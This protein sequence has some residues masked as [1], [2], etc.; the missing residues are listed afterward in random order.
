MTTF[1]LLGEDHFVLGR[2]VHTL[3]VLMYLA[4]NTVVR[5]AA[6]AGREQETSS[7]R[8][9]RCFLHHHCALG[10]AA[11]RLA[12]SLSHVCYRVVK[13]AEKKWSERRHGIQTPLHNL[14][15]LLAE[16]LLISV[17]GWAHHFA[18]LLKFHHLQNKVNCNLDVHNSV[19]QGPVL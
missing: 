3:A 19:S 1:D 16:E 18:L 17:E 6:G 11:L 7:L 9:P 5:K 4:V 12:A 10:P 2:L 14:F 15:L 13:R 8:A